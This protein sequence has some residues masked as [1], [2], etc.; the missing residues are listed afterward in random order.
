MVVALVG[1]IFGAIVAGIIRAGFSGRGLFAFLVVSALSQIVLFVITNFLQIGLYRSAL[2]VTAGQRVEFG[3]VFTA[4]GAGP[5][6]VVAILYAL[7]VGIGTLLCII[8]GIIVAFL[9]FF[10]PYFVLDQGLAPVDAIKASFRMVNANL[11]QMIPFAILAFIVYVVGFIACGIGVLVTG[12]VA[13][14]AV[15][16]AYRTLNG[17][18]VA[19]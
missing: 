11:G 8:P 10:A 9:G 7:M 12:P 17:Q 3:Q 6:L 5:Y 2:A 18:P 16:F 13:L 14:L 15:A 1:S 19:A 4:E